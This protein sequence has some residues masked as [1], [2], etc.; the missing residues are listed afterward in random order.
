M[1]TTGKPKIYVSDFISM[2]VDFYRK[3]K[4]KYMEIEGIT[5][6]EWTWRARMGIVKSETVFP[7]MP[8]GLR[9]EDIPNHEDYEIQYT[10][11][12]KKAK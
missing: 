12:G 5:S 7:M 1:T 3:V 10:D 6:D 11:F 8:E 2:R 4:E 9:Q